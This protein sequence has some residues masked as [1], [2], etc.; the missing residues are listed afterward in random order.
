MKEITCKA[1]LEGNFTNHSGKRT[2]ATQLY[3]AG[4]DEQEI[5]S[6]TGHRSEKAVRKYKRSNAELQGRVSE[7]LNP[8]NITKKLKCDST[9]DRVSDPE[10]VREESP[11]PIL[12]GCVPTFGSGGENSV[13]PGSVFN[14]CVFHF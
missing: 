11:K 7:V 13:K 1:G 6:R 14:N 3:H 9:D 4:I 5:M 12:T 2:C 10:I 8:P